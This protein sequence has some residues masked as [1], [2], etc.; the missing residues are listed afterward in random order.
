MINPLFTFV[1]LK[2]YFD[3]TF[4]EKLAYVISQIH[5]WTEIDVDGIT[6]DV[7][8]T[9][10]VFAEKAEG[11]DC[12][13]TEDEQRESI[14]RHIIE[15]FKNKCAEFSVNIEIATKNG[16]TYYRSVS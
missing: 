8:D 15:H 11:E 16:K 3:K 13:G 4:D 14:R 6:N 10:W 1:A 7:L 2:G 5:D 9:M 12:L